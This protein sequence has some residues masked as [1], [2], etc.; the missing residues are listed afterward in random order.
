MTILSKR[1]LQCAKFLLEGKTAKEIAALSGLSNRT[2]E[3]YLD[4]LKNKLRCNN[5]VE[6]VLKLKDIT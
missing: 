2:V 3:H 4:N 1:Q 5:K 6:L